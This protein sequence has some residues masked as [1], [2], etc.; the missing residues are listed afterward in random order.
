MIQRRRAL[1]G[2]IRRVVPIVARL[3]P[4]P[5][6]RSSSCRRGRRAARSPRQWRSPRC[7]GTFCAIRSSAIVSCRSCPMRPAPSGWIRCFA[8]SR[9]APRQL[10]EPVDHDLLLSYTEALDGQL[11]EEGITEAGS[12]ASWIAAGTSYANTGVPMVPFYTFYSMF[13]F[14]RIGDLAVAGRRCPHPRLPDGGHG[15]PD[16][17]DGRRPSA[18]GRSQPAAR[19]DHSGL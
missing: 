6:H 5:P 12:M 19:V 14:Q 13:G 16:H 8:S 15:G 18:P 2:F 17:A 1:H 10:Y 9:S 4:R 3:P 11:L 7:F